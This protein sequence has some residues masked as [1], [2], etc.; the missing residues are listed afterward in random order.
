MMMC[1]NA[2]NLKV[3]RYAE[4]N[5]S[6]RIAL[7][8]N[9]IYSTF[10]PHIYPTVIFQ[11]KNISPKMNSFVTLVVLKQK[12]WDL[13]DT[14][15]IWNFLFYLTMQS[16]PNSLST[17]TNNDSL[18]MHNHRETGLLLVF[19]LSFFASFLSLLRQSFSRLGCPQTQRF[20]GLCF[21][22][23]GIKGVRHHRPAVLFERT[24]THP[25]SF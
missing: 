19:F 21:P 13:M 18:L 12:N 2:S 8:L 3:L 5:I 11:E 1:Q 14:E 6:A 15:I 7:S 25:S 16:L 9:L 17:Q 20:T 4:L 24:L 23:T 22:N 10:I